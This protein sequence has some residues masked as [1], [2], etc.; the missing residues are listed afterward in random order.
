MFSHSDEEVARLL[1]EDVDAGDED[2]DDN[3][4]DDSDDDGDDG[5][6][7]EQLFM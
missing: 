1:E 7:G 4:D 2:E 3:E 5:D 6:N